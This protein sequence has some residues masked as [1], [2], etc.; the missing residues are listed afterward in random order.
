VKINEIAVSLIETPEE[1]V[2]RISEDSRIA[3][4]E[5][6]NDKW[7]ELRD[8]VI[9]GP[10]AEKLMRTKDCTKNSGKG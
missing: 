5:A 1:W 8:K 2:R 10:E 4:S 7:I 3:S 9:E 6:L